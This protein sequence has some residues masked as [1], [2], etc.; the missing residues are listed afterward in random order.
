MKRHRIAAGPSSDPRRGAAAVELALVLPVLLT[1]LL[2]VWDLGRLIDA[3][4]ILNN[5][6]REGGRCASTG[7]VDV[8]GIQDAV[9]N[10]LTQAGLSKVGATVT[11]TNLTKSTN[12]DPTTADQL[13]QFQIT[14]TLPS[15]SVRWIALNNLIGS[16]TLSATCTWSSMRD[17]PLTVDPTIPVN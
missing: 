1:I 13:D 4:Q 16:N 3:T 15:S 11:V 17:I 7:Q 9:L 10:Y 12:T 5:A 8:A 6:T 2:A 14:T